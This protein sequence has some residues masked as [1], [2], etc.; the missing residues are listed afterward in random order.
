MA[1]GAMSAPQAATSGAVI[2]QIAQNATS[3]A[4]DVTILPCCLRSQDY[5]NAQRIL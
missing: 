5:I 3:Q 1:G 2:P 4:A